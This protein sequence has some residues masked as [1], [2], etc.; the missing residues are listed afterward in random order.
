MIR[1][2]SACMAVYIL[3]ACSDKPR[4]DDR[5]TDCTYEYFLFEG[6]RLPP[7]HIKTGD[8]LSA[9]SEMRRIPSLVDATELTD[10]NALSIS[11]L[12]R[13]FYESNPSKYCVLAEY[14]AL[15]DR[16]RLRIRELSHH[17]SVDRNLAG[18]VCT[19]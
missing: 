4:C 18:I 5:S 14:R 13:Y 9:D 1:A 11:I 7:R 12:L 3:V 6:N 10:T 17:D 2:I 16:F 8:L 15:V 19:S